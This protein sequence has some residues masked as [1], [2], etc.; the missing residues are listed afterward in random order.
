MITKLPLKAIRLKPGAEYHLNVEWRLARSTDWAPKNHLLAWDQMVLPQR[1][2]ELASPALTGTAPL[3]IQPRAMDLVVEGRDFKLRFD[4]QSGALE[5]FIFS[6]GERL[7]GPLE[8]NFWRAMTDNDMAG[9]DRKLMLKDSGI[10]MDAAARRKVKEF[11]PGMVG[12]AV[13]LVVEFELLD[14]KASLTKTY[15]IHPNA[16]VQVK[17]ELKTNGSLPE[18]PRVGLQ[19]QV[20]GDFNRLTWL[21]RGPQENY[22]D[23]RHS[24][25]VGLFEDNVRTMNHDYIRPQEHGNH[26][27]VR[28]A[29]LTARDGRGLLVMHMGELL[30]TS[31]WPHTQDDLEAA[32]HTVDLPTRDAITWNIDHAQRGLGG[33]NSW[34]AKPLPQYR[35]TD[36]NYTYEFVLR[37]VS[38]GGAG[39]LS[40]MGRRPVPAL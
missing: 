24:T 20:P 11:T 39:S 13:R 34:G 4:R 33:I 29:A 10:W 32:R 1:G 3:Q 17:F 15:L 19:V 12:Q 23:R 5:S 27:D 7:A 36:R 25:Y 38:A 8:P 40:E 28:W 14:G 35:L 37:P 22:Q 16:D 26:I 21:G 9:T 31:A 18:I 6:G 30:N 2:P